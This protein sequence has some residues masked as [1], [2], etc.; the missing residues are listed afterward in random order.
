M[1]KPATHSLV[2]F[3]HGVGSNGADLLQ[4]A[5][6]W[7]SA[8]PG[9]RFVAPDAPSPSDFGTGRQWFSVAGITAANRAGRVLAAREGFNRTLTEIVS[10]HEL[11]DHLERVVLVGFSQGSIMAL[12]ALSSGSWPVAAIV[13]FSGR[14]A[15]PGPILPSRRTRLLLIHGQADPVIPAEE[16][17]KAAERLRKHGIDV[18]LVLLPGVGHTISRDGAMVAAYTIGKSLRS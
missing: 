2:I 17:V 7:R 13:C 14:L 3:L 1:T 10:A 5:N 15:S 8:L 18:D 11:G 12:D 4:L 6:S 9:T 16:S